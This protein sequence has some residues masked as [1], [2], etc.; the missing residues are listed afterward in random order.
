MTDLDGRRVRGQ[1]SRDAIL[2]QAV[3]LASTEGLD[4]LSLARLARATGVSKSAFFAH[5]PGKEQLQLDAVEWA[6]RQWIERIV[7]PALAAPKGVR[8]LLALHES[9]LRFYTT[10][11]L[12]GGCFFFA[13]QAEFDDKPGPVRDRIARCLREWIGLIERLAGEALALGEL[14]EDV[15]VGQLAYEIDALGLAVVARSRLL[16]AADG[17]RDGASADY[18][19]RAVRQRLRSLCPDPDLLPK[20]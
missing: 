3:L 19:R 13:V 1:R 11:V 2:E 7:G 20:G 16:P 5:W 4:G 6:E 9:R 12:P 10:A 17:S 18:S 14:D 15:D 8:R